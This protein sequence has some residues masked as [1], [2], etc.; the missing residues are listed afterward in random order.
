MNLVKYH[1]E[2]TIKLGYHEPDFVW[3]QSKYEEAR[4]NMLNSNRIQHTY[5]DVLE[6]MAELDEDGCNGYKIKKYIIQT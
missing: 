5:K 4:R 1:R 3:K 6:Q 2:R